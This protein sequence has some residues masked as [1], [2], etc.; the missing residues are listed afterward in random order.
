MQQVSSKCH[1]I[2]KSMYFSTTSIT[3]FFSNHEILPF[4]RVLFQLVGGLN[5][6]EKYA[7]QNGNL[8]QFSEYIK[9]YLE[10]PP[11]YLEP[12]SYWYGGNP[13]F[14]NYFLNISI[15]TSDFFTSAI[16]PSQNFCHLGE[17]ELFR[18]LVALCKLGQTFHLRCMAS[19]RH[20]IT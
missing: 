10:P 14:V 17:R 7:R 13:L 11:S 15:F 19:W 2:S 6:F 8:P 16:L 18:S 1:I 20:H 5:P 9:T 3:F 12:P 4:I